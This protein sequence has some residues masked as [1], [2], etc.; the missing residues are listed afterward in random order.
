ML[1][2]A[3]FAAGTWRR[4]TTLEGKKM[5]CSGTLP[6]R[7]IRTR[8]HTGALGLATQFCITQ[9]ILGARIP[10]PLGVADWVV[11]VTKSEL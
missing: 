11:W 10:L 2:L 4:K 1:T 6:R 8:A 7:H 3:F 5:N 9:Y